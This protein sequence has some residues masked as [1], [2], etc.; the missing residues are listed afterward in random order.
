LDELDSLLQRMLELPV[1]QIEDDLG[2][3]EP[4]SRTLGKGRTPSAKPTPPRPAVS[5]VTPE[6]V[7]PGRPDAAPETPRAART[8]PP[9][10]RPAAEPRP[11]NL[12]PRLV[13]DH[14]DEFDRYE[15]KADYDPD[16]D[17]PEEAPAAPP[18]AVPAPPRPATEPEVWVPLQSSWKPSPQTWQPLAENWQQAL[19]ALGHDPAAPARPVTP[20]ANVV[21]ARAATPEPPPLAPAAKAPPAG[22]PIPTPRAVVPPPRPAPAPAQPAPAASA[23]PVSAWLWP[24]VWFNAVFDLC[25]V[26]FGAPGKWLRGRGGRTV[27]G[28]LGILSLLAAAALAAADWFGWTW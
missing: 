20:P 16:A 22:E 14:D 1:N 12:E 19:A 10:P 27:L 18:P 23:P 9:P 7:V 28:G 15:G 2:S 8:P 21:S 25:L 4:P 26:P 11:I 6:P 5:Y 3:E 13:T 17:E 24:L